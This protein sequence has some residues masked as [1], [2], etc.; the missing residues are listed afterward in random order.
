MQ[1]NAS[2]RNTKIRAQR[3]TQTQFHSPY[4]LPP[5]QQC[6]QSLHQLP[7]PQ[8]DSVC[9]SLQLSGT[10]MQSHL[11]NRR[12]PL[13]LLR[14]HLS[15]RRA[16]LRRSGLQ[17]RMR[18]RKV[19]DLNVALSRLISL[20]KTRTAMLKCHFFVKMPNN[21]MM[22]NDA[23]KLFFPPMWFCRQMVTVICLE[24]KL[25]CSKLLH[26]AVR[27]WLWTEDASL[28]GLPALLVSLDMLLSFDSVSF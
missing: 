18:F 5:A 21:R 28:I 25:Y 14:T 9:R 22:L 13:P 23:Q 11:R 10:I 20:H 7:S 19:E 27:L 1:A 15:I 17:H 12:G 24:K 8:E 16:S 3:L 26:Q 2:I 6:R 4:P